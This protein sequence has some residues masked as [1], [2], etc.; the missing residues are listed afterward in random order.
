MKKA[1]GKRLKA[2]VLKMAAKMPPARARMVLAAI[3][4]GSSTLLSA[5]RDGGDAASA[6]AL[7]EARRA[8]EKDVR[9]VVTAVVDA[10]MAGD[11]HALEGL[12]AMLPGLLDAVNDEPELAEILT[13]QIGTEVLRGMRISPE[14]AA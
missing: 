6:E 2:E 1:E 3:A 12:R 9:P 11:T 5:S 7:Q 14:E 10:L 4:A 8:F 13:G